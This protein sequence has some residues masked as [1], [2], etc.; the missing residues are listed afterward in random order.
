MS[1][2]V[3]KLSKYSSN[4]VKVH[5]EGLVHLLRYIRD[6]NTLGLIYYAEMKDSPLSGLLRQDS[7]KTDNKLMVFYDY[8]WQDFPD[9]GRSIGL[10][11]IFYQ[12]GPIDHFTHVPRPVDQ[13]IAKIDYNA[14]YTAGM[15]LANFRVLTH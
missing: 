14:A 5:F 1:F 12:V 6:N 2:S 8:S 9:T 15:A 4:N 13:S 10:Y 3:Q 11:I 7:I